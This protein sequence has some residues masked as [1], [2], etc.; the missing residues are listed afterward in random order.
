MAMPPQLA[1]ANRRHSRHSE[2]RPTVELMPAICITD[3]RDAIPRNYGTNIYS[4]PFRYPQIRHLRLSYRSIEI[5]D[6]HDRSQVFG[7]QWIPTY[8]GKH[9]A[10]FVCSSCRGGAIRLFGKDGNY[11]C[12]FC[13]RAQYLSQKQK[14]ASRK[15]LAAAKLRLKLRGW[16]DIREPLP[17]KPKWTRRRTYQRI[18]N[19]IQ[20]LEAKAKQTRFRKQIDIRTFGYHVA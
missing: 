20:A 4:S 19:E 2:P 10:I 3:L 7:I 14:T 1:R 15:R 6:H 9:R 8:F 16:P 12:R 18:C 11:A 17:S 13:H 5:V